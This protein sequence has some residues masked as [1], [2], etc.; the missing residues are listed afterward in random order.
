[1]TNHNQVD[2]GGNFLIIRHHLKQNLFLLPHYLYH[3]LFDYNLNASLQT[4]NG[5]KLL[6][7][8]MRKSNDK[9]LRK[10]LQTMAKARQINER[11]NGNS[12]NSK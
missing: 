9:D 10:T 8:K 5:K 7:Q 2:K 6:L 12:K 3:L 4:G 1:M 11:N